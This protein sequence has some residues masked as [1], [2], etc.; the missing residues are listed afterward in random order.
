MRDR[1]RSLLP[2]AQA[3]LAVAL[4]SYS[5]WRSNSAG[6]SPWTEPA[7]EACSA[8]NAPATVATRLLRMAVEAWTFPYPVLDLVLDRLVFVALVWLQWHLVSIETRG[9]GQSLLTSR[10]RFRSLADLL[11]VIFGVGLGCIGLPG[12]RQHALNS[13]YAI[14][15]SMLYLAWGAVIAVFY[16]HDLW[17]V[18]TGQAARRGEG[19]RLRP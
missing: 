18:A 13:E 1:L 19:N 10:I 7:W 15:L 4:M 9:R 2:P 16:G 3:V 5:F 6:R 14:P 12:T 11:A 8:L 17:R